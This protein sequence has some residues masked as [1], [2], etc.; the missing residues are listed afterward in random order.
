MRAPELRRWIRAAIAASAVPA[1]GL[2]VYACGAT[3]PGGGPPAD[4]GC[5]IIGRYAADAVGCGMPLTVE[6]TGSAAACGFDDGGNQ[7]SDCTSLCGSASYACQLV[8]AGVVSCQSACAG[9]RPA[10][11]LARDSTPSG[12]GLAGAGSAIDAWLSAAAYLEAASVPA[13]ASLRDDLTRLGAPR[14]LRR[15]ASRAMHDE[16]RHAATMR[17]LAQRLGRTPPSTHVR[18]RRAEPN[19]AARSLAE[20]A[21]ENAREGCVRETYGAL[22]AQVQ[23]DR[24]AD[25]RVRATLRGIAGDEARH[26]ALSWRVHAWARAHLGPEGRRRLDDATRAAARELAREVDAR[27]PATELTR[28]LG[29]PGSG[30]AARMLSALG[31]ADA[32]RSPGRQAA[33]RPLRHGGAFA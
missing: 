4:A 29:L 3:A 2:A 19:D 15:A 6:F 20:V 31:L 28:T 23:A 1:A 32:A 18:L 5:Q 16:A 12:G 30:E 7:G 27:P 8:D 25:P 22:V 13:F 14:S 24:A 21:I 11:L 33:R 26:A 10:R 9:R 17:G